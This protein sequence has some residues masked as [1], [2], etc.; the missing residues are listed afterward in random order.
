M[1]FYFFAGLPHIHGTQESENFE[2]LEFHL[3]Y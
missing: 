3:L 1:K 2:I